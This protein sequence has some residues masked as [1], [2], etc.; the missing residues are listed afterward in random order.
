MFLAIVVIT[1]AIFASARPN[2]ASRAQHFT[3]LEDIEGSYDYVIIG[4]GTSGLTVADRLTEDGKSL[5][6]DFLLESEWAY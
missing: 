6:N 2:A 3:R 5:Y 4:G 1:F